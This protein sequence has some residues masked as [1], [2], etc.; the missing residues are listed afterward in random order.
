MFKLAEFV[1]TF[2]TKLIIGGIIVLMIIGGY[3]AWNARGDKID[4]LKDQAVVAK[5]ENGSLKDTVG[6]QEASGAI[7]EKVETE[8]VKEVAKVIKKHETID[9]KRI[10]KVKSIEDSFAELP[11]TPENIKASDTQTSTA[12]IEGL[13][14]SYCAEAPPGNAACPAPIP[15]V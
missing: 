6:K 1:A 2:K 8:A 4:T 5:I 10:A 9:A 12:L 11:K 13:W 14:E 7:T 3:L 15:A